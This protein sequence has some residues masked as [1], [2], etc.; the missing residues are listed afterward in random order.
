[1]SP[2][3]YGGM[4]DDDAT[5]GRTATTATRSWCMENWNLERSLQRS[6]CIRALWH[7]RSLARM[8]S[9]GLGC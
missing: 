9:N 1:M 5:M 8:L 6:V 4:R 3:F 2:S 7:N